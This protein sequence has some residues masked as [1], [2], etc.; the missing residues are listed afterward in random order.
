MMLFVKAVIYWVQI[1]LF[2]KIPVQKKNYHEHW[3]G[4][5]ERN[6]ILEPKCFSLVQL[7]LTNMQW[8]YL[9][10]LC[11]PN[12]LFLESSAVFLSVACSPALIYSSSEALFQSCRTERYHRK[13]CLKRE[14]NAE[15]DRLRKFNCNSCETWHTFVFDNLK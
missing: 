4:T 14:N 3:S 12:T 6:L 7:I 5:L 9:W 1:K 8:I 13:G 11:C 2:E 10:C 15:N